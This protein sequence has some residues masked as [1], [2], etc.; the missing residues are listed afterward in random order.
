MKY[1]SSLG[2]IYLFY[3]LK[4]SLLPLDL[5]HHLLDMGLEA[6]ILVTVSLFW[7]NKSWGTGTDVLLHHIFSSL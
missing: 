5:F 6:V 1:L 7:H 2:L 3:Y 4:F